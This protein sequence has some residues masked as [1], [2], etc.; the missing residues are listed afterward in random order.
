MGGLEVSV[1]DL[2]AMLLAGGTSAVCDSFVLTFKE[3]LLALVSRPFH[4]ELELSLLFSDF[5]LL[6]RLGN[7]G[8]TQSIVF[9][10]F[11][12]SEATFNACTKD[13][14]FELIDLGEEKF[15]RKI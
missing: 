11:H 14:D 1:R 7:Y 4:S 9:S 5:F 12:Q 3:L 10:S 15:I 6:K 2:L 8:D 13:V